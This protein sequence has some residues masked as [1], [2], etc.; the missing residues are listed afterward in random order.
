M[1]PFV[2]W[3]DDNIPIS[4]LSEKTGLAKITLTS[5]LDRLEV[6][7]HI[8]RVFDPKDRRKVNITLTD[9]TK[10]LKSHYD[11]VSL[12]M[13]QIFYEGFSDNEI[14]LIENALMRILDNLTERNH[15]NE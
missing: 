1:N 7:G 4:E 2:L 14:I 8:Q 9:S 13:N 15:G 3:D 11:E 5:M 6:S 12:R 10:N